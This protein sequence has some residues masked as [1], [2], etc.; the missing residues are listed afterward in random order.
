[1]CTIVR[2][3]EATVLIFSIHVWELWSLIY[4]V[5]LLSPQFFV[6]RGPG[7]QLQQQLLQQLLPSRVMMD[8]AKILVGSLGCG[9]SGAWGAWATCTGDIHQYLQAPDSNRKPREARRRNLFVE[10]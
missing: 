7:Q 5:Q 8:L 4:A 6:A 1:M 10:S 9:A 2:Q 3:H